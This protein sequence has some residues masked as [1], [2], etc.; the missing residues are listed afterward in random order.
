MFPLSSTDCVSL[1][2][3]IVPEA[4][5]VVVEAFGVGGQ[6][7]SQIFTQIAAATLC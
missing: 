5:V 7:M 2:S 4:A 3:M 6:N 1:Y